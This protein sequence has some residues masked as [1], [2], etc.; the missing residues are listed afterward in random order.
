M[1]TQADKQRDRFSRLNAALSAINAVASQIAQ[2]ALWLLTAVVLWD[3]LWRSFGVPTIWGAEV[4]VYLMLALAFLGI[5]HTWA[6][7]GHFRVTLMVG[8]F[9]P[10][11]QLAIEFF[12]T[13]LALVFTTAFTYGACKLAI[14]S[15]QLNFTTPT[16]LKV[17]VGILYG[18]VV[19]GGLSLAIAL[20]QDL[21]RILRG[22][23]RHAHTTDIWSA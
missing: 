10:R 22:N 17:P 12:C 2:A 5:G 18:L 19:L 7:D 9:R 23:L 15:F 1:N 3:V 20:I 13:L 16:V 11:T 14:F 6:E 21:I 4:S 8:R